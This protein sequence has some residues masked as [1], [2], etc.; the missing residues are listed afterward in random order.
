MPVPKGML[1]E[2]APVP[3]VTEALEPPAAVEFTESA[4]A[5]ALGGMME[6]GSS[7]GASFGS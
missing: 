7:S 4:A 3:S 6:G 1:G 2:C 5:T